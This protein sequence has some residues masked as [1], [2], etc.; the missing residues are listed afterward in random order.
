MEVLMEPASLSIN[1]VEPH[2]AGC[3]LLLKPYCGEA[4]YTHLTVN[5][6]TF[7]TENDF[8]LRTMIM[9]RLQMCY[10]AWLPKHHLIPCFL[11]YGQINHFE[12]I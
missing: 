2:S 10:Q 7:Y 11:P 1:E 8:N 9:M 5:L 3:G 12:D 4:V 6:K